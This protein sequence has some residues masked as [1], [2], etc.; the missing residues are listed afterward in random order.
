[1]KTKTKIVKEEKRPAGA[2]YYVDSL[3]HKIKDDRVYIWINC[4]WKRS[5]KTAAELNSRFNEINSKKKYHRRP[6]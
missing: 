3:W 6:K 5:T 1:M 4:E 2:M